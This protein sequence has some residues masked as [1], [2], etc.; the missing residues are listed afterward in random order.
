VARFAFVVLEVLV[1]HLATFHLRVW[2]GRTHAANHGLASA[3]FALLQDLVTIVAI[4]RVT[5]DEI[6]AYAAYTASLGATV[7]DVATQELFWFVLGQR[8]L[9]ASNALARVVH[10][11]VHAITERAAS[12]ANAI[13][14]IDACGWFR[15]VP[16]R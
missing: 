1:S 4:A 5:F 6:F 2:D 10:E 14:D 16:S 11:V 8:L 15:E 13:V 12:V 7:V 9:V 3:V